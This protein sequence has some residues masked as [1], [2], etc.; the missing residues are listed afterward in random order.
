MLLIKSELLELLRNAVE[1]V[2]RE[3]NLP[4]EILDRPLTLEVPKMPEHGDFATTFALAAAKQARINPRELAQKILDRLPVG[5]G[6]LKSAELA[7]PGFI[8]L[9]IADASLAA[10]LRRVLDAGDDWGRG[11]PVAGRI[12]LEFVSA[13]PTGPMHVGH[14]R[15]AAVG[16][17]LAR[18]LRFGGR[19]VFT[20][21]YV[22]DAGRQVS[23]LAAS[24]WSRYIDLCR[25]QDDSIEAVPFPEDGYHGGYVV[26]FARSYLER[27][28][29]A[30]AR[31]GYDAA[32][33]KAFGVELA[34]A[35]IR[36]TLEQFNVRFDVFTSEATLHDDGA[37]T[38]AMD[39]LA[40]KGLT[41]EQEGALF[42][43]ATRFGDEKDR[44][45]IRA[46]GEPTYFAADIAYHLH[47][48]NRGFDQL[49]D[50]WGADHHGYI[51][52]VKCAL[53]AF[54][55][56][57]DQLEVLLV[58][59]VS[60]VNQGEKLAMGK[61]SG[62]FVTLQDLIDT[63]S[64]DVTRWFFLAKTHDV[65]VD[66]D[67]EVATSA[68]PRENPARYV[69]YGHARACAIWRRAAMWNL[70]V[71]DLSSADFTRLAAPEEQ[72]I[73]RMLLSYPELVADAAANCL[74]HRVA[75][76]ALDLCRAFH[77]YYTRFKDDPILPRSGQELADRAKTIDRL[78][79]VEAY[80]TVLRS[81][82][83]LL[84]ITAPEAMTAPEEE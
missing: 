39:L 67:L 40:G 76:Y 3:N 10:G 68:D 38:R 62:N 51:S 73:A 84:G 45:M 42:F 61:R 52:R 21:Y 64:C 17:A 41:Y 27:F 36:T 4:V 37:V 70:T 72:A 60:L 50:I 74:P 14:G 20:E 22:N 49:M 6:P 1:Q 2:V 34:M 9:R 8:N 18:I 29:L 7:G 77:S 63:V 46:N 71:A 12:N 83:S 58:Q 26:D 15:G 53:E 44:V 80:R 54:G 23:H 11:A 75:S 35:E 13:N 56:R 65:A 48:F 79:L 5:Q 59:F 78:G 30:P 57:Q 16:D 55:Y 69:Q 82:L 31:A 25:E 28:G 43:A 24:I 66:F 19:E 47:K 33:M 81:C 32:A